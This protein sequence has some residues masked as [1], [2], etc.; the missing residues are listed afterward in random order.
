MIN[1]MICCTFKYSLKVW[2]TSV[3][4]APLLFIMLTY[5]SE[6]FHH[7]DMHELL[8]SSIFGYMAFVFLEVCLSTI[9][10]FVFLVAVQYTVTIVSK[11]NLR[12]W[13]VFIEGILLTA[14]TFMVVL[15]PND[16]FN[17]SDKITVMMLCNCLCMGW[18]IWYYDL[19][20]GD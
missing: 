11:P 5:C 19:E 20:P 4:V 13:L 9:T 14:G 2:L 18:G 8:H 6:G 12:I 3:M 17:I 1:R 7:R 16:V 10:W 15:S